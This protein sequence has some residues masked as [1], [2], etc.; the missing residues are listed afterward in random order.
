MASPASVKVGDPMTGTAG[1][2]L[3]AARVEFTRHAFRRANID[4]VA[5]RAGVSRR[6]LYRHFPTKEA[7]FEHLVEADTQALFAELGQA[8]RRQDAAGAIVECFTLAM[9][10]ITENPLVTAVIESEPELVIG[11]N[12]PNGERAFVRVSNLVASTLRLCGVTM[13]D[14]S[15]LATAEILVRLVGSLLTNRAG[16]LDITDTVAVRKYAETY[17]ARLVW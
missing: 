12:T 17:L 3:A 13:P 6:T 2:I 7:L 8:A 5:Q 14:E 11:L 16:V 10:R 1:A 9:R 4:A 15:V